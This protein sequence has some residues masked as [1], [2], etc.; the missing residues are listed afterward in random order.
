[1]VRFASALMLCL[2]VV[3]CAATDRPA[4]TGRSAILPPEILSSMRPGEEEFSPDQIYLADLPEEKR[5]DKIMLDPILYFAPLEQMRTVSSG[6]RQI[7]LNNFYIILNREL[8]KD[9]AVVRSPQAGAARVQFA[10]RPV[11]RDAL[12]LDT[13][14]MV[15]P[16]S[17]PGEVVR[18]LLASP[19]IVRNEFVVEAEWT[20]SLTG[21]VLGAT[22]DRNFGRQTIEP[23][24]IKSWADVNQILQDYAAL[25]RFRLCR[26]REAE[27]CTPPSDSL[28]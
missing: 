22:V 5:Y 3:G 16:G 27:D 10:I 28:R 8:S 23:A 13:V 14:S 19:I 25:T 1:M 9:Y 7:L 4:D 20:D 18:D 2:L 21:A 24:D 17:E 26:F 12:A 11:T 6:D 15:A